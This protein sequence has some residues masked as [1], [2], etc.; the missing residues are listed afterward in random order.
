MLKIAIGSTNPAKIRAVES[1]F[2][3]MGLAVEIVPVAAPS[4]VAN[5]PFTDEE[6]MRGARN[7]AEYCLEKGNFDIGIGLEGGV[8]EMGSGLFLTN[9]GALAVK[10]MDT[11]TASGA[12]I[13]LPEDISVHLRSGRE[14]GPVMEEYSQ[15]KNV[16]SN[17]GA[18]GIFTNGEVNRDEMFAHILRLLAGQYVYLK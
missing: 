3:G 14:L 5:Q 12:R 9:W 4:G 18:I 6:T 13:K 16:R 7:R 17:E 2:V 15:K 1:V 8:M 10:G 11:L